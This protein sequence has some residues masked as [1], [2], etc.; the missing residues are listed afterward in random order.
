M[1]KAVLIVHEIF[2]VGLWIRIFVDYANESCLNMV[3]IELENRK[4]I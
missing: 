4:M 3:K 1:H 2:V